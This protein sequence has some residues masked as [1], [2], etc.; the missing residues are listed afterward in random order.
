MLIDSHTHIFPQEYRKSHES[1]LKIDKTYADLFRKDSP[2]ADAE[3]LVGSMERNSISKS[4]ILGMGWTDYGLALDINDYLIESSKNHPDKLIP[5]CSINPAWGED[6]LYE[7]ERCFNKGA[8]GIGELHP[9][10]QNFDITSVAEM[11]GIMK[12]CEDKQLPVLIH[13]SEPIGH[14]YPGKGQTHPSKLI[15]FINNFQSNIIICAHFGGG[16]PFYSMMPEIRSSLTNV[17]FDSAAAP[18]LYEPGVYSNVE[19]L[20]GSKHLLFGSDY[21]VV[22]HKRSLEHLMKSEMDSDS[23]MDITHN[24]I[25]SILSL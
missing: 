24:N 18:Y 3:S 15:H 16:L 19:Q 1:I 12:F 20:L 9:D 22:S 7:L 21:P 8:R 23:F 2:P 14:S 5:F 11:E 17:Y 25:T 6:A 13:C 10:T 4:I